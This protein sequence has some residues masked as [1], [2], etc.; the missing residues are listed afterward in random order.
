MPKKRDAHGY[1]AS[2]CCGLSGARDTQGYGGLALKLLFALDDGTIKVVGCRRS[3][4]CRV[5]SVNGTLDV[6]LLGAVMVGLE[7]ETLKFTGLVL[8]LLVWMMWHSRLCG[9]VPSRLV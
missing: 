3:W 6:M 8:S 5:R 4:R 1:K 7:D 9:L 2:S